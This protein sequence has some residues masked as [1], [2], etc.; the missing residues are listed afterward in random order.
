MGSKTA[1]F[2][3]KSI[4]DGRSYHL[5]T[6]GEHGGYRYTPPKTSGWNLKMD[7]LSIC[8]LLSKGAKIQL[9][10]PFVF[11]TVAQDL[12]KQCPKSR[13]AP[14]FQR[15]W[16]T[17]W[18]NHPF[19][20]QRDILWDIL[21][22][23]VCVLYIIYV[24]YIL[25]KIF[26]NIQM[27]IFLFL[28]FFLF[29]GVSFLDLRQLSRVQRRATEEHPNRHRN[30]HLRSRLHGP[31]SVTWFFPWNFANPPTENRIFQSHHGCFLKGRSY[32]KY[33]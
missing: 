22:V 26:H 14:N 18:A 27:H 19:V 10:Q 3:F 8:F 9:N 1:S 16:S 5:D 2:T 15:S 4:L 20:K 24:Y 29:R 6:S 13:M 7:S 33:V 17:F 25:Y 31:G 21:K 12:R 23:C 30:C 32:K 11:V 28:L